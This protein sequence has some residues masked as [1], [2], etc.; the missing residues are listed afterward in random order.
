M[1]CHTEFMSFSI[2]GWRVVKCS[3]DLSTRVS[4][5]IRRYTDHMKF[6]ACMAFWFITF[7]RVL[8]GPYFYYCLYDCT[9]CRLLLNFV[10]YL[11]IFLWL[12]VLI[13]MYVLFSIYYVFIV[14]TGTLRLPWLRFFRASSSVVRQMPGYN[15]AKT[16]H[17]QHSSQ[18]GD[19]FYVVSSSLI[20]VRLLWVRIPESLPTEFVNFVVLCTVCV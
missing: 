2:V 3:E 9:F 16:G 17:G 20:L 6:V 14:P 13:V 11:F 8:L 12:C 19:N 10:S 1:F 15:F 18:L 7:F 4:N 5:I